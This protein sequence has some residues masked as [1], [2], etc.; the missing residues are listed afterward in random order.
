MEAFPF[1]KSEWT[2]VSDATLPVVNAGL[3]EDAV[4]RAFYLVGLIDVLAGL[5]VRYGDHPVLLETEA[6]FAEGDGERVTLY[7]RAAGIAAAHGLPTLSIRLSLARVL[8]DLGQPAEA[9]NELSLCESELTDTDDSERTS[10]S[11][12]V[13]ETKQAALNFTSDLAD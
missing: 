8:L 1:T 2:A 11:D 4:L 10:W 9:A 3:A 12:L 13:I 5:R 7:Q 6:D